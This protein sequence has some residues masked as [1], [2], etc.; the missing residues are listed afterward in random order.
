MLKPSTRITV[1]IENQDL[2]ALRRQAQ[3]EGTKIS[4]QIRRAIKRYAKSRRR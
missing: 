4:E 2:A 3:R 1:R